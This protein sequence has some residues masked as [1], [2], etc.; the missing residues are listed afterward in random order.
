VEKGGLKRELE[1]L[2]VSSTAVL[3]W[4][5][6]MRF[7]LMGQ[8]RKVWGVRGVKPVQRIQMKREWGY[9]A[10]AVDGR[11]GRLYWGWQSDMKKES[12]A[13]TLELF[14]QAGV[15]AVVWD[16]AKGHRAH[17]TRAVAVKQLIQPPYSPELNPAE[18]IFEEV[19]RAVEGRIYRNVAQKQAAIEAFISELAADS[20]RIRRLAGW[21]WIEENLAALPP[22]IASP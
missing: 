14:R 21:K 2:G 13:A 18:R 22:S 5:D 20:E 7:G 16:G 17:L 9:L 11:A 10:L 12:C 4:G 19:R 15:A 1:E 6:E 8:V 3:A